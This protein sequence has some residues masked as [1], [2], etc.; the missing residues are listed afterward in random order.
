ML[1]RKRAKNKD[2]ILFLHFL[3]FIRE[4]INSYAIIYF[5]SKLHQ[6]SLPVLQQV[7]DYL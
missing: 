7:P 1:Q 6:L 4:L 3:L 5:F 2:F